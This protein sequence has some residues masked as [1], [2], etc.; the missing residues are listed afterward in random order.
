LLAAGQ[1]EGVWIVAVGLDWNRSDIDLLHQECLLEESDFP[2][3]AAERREMAAASC[4]AEGM[5]SPFLLFASEENPAPRNNT[6]RFAEIA[7]NRVLFIILP[8]HPSS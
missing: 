2:N 3:G 8:K 5:R 7:R 6:H 1:V 4:R